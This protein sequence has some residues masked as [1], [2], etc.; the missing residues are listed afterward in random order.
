MRHGRCTIDMTAAEVTADKPKPE[1]LHQRILADIEGRILS[2]EWP[3]GRQIPFE[4]DLA[5]HYGCSRMTVNKV[6]TQL[7]AAGLIERRRKAG[8]FVRR[9]Q[10]YSAVLE[11][12]DIGKEVEAL[13]LPYRFEI[14]HA[15]RRASTRLDASRLELQAPAEMLDIV[16]RH[17]A[18]DQP[19][20][21]EE[22]PWTMAEHKIRAIGA[23][24]AAA[25]ALGIAVGTPCLSIERRTWRTDR[26]VTFVR[27]TY[28]GDGHEV[29]ARFAPSQA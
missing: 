6:M 7:A 24:K 5:V 13:G 26:P 18:A 20:C 25:E 21:V 12:I 27:L 2:A 11:I 22:V 16:C 14:T 23:D 17:F 15:H 28:P 10:S 8:S 1:S 19:F 29:L 9:P 3:P 4:Q